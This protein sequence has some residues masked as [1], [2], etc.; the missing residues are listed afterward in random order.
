MLNNYQYSK[1]PLYKTLIKLI[2]FIRHILIRVTFINYLQEDYYF[3]LLNVIFIEIKI[4][5]IRVIIIN[6]EY[7]YI[8]RY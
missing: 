3:F 4:F 8:M 6:N 2:E 1:K 7:I 5:P